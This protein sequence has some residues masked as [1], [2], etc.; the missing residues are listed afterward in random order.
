MALNWL[1][2]ILSMTSVGK[3]L[4]CALVNPLMASCGISARVA[5]VSAAILAVGM[6]LS[7]LESSAPKSNVTVAPVVLF[8]LLLT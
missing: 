5:D 1:V 6:L 4:I 8:V 3:A 7:W 2:E